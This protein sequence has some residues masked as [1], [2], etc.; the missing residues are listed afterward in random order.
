MAITKE[1]RISFILCAM[2]VLVDLSIVFGLVAAVVISLDVVTS[3]TRL[4]FP[5]RSMETTRSTASPIT[6]C[7]GCWLASGVSCSSRQG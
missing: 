6:S 1:A 2:A 7:I 3:R 4:P 5:V